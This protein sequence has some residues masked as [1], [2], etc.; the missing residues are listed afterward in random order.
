MYSL[1]VSPTGYGIRDMFADVESYRLQS[2]RLG[3]GAQHLLLRRHVYAEGWRVDLLKSTLYHWAGRRAAQS[4][5]FLQRG[6]EL[7]LPGQLMTQGMTNHATPGTPLYQEMLDHGQNPNQVSC[8][9]YTIT[10]LDQMTPNQIYLGRY[11]QITVDGVDGH[12]IAEYWDPF[13]NKWQIA[14]S[15]F[16]LVYFDPNTEMGQG[17]E[18]VNALLLAGNLSDI[19]FLWVTSNGS[20]YMTNY[21]LDPITMYN[22]VYPFGNLTI[23]S[24]VLNYVPNSPLPFLNTSS[25]GAQGTL[26]IYIFQFAN[27]SD[28]LTVNN[29]G[30]L[31]TDNSGKH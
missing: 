21:Y 19:D 26:G 14:D 5:G 22:N 12:V 3:S 20:S 1:I 25:L 17:A 18:D 31:V 11:R 2:I 15:T 24:L 4:P 23:S 13:N 29:A 9:Y 6:A 16:G 7:H 28:Q 10:L 27:Q 30:T 8:G